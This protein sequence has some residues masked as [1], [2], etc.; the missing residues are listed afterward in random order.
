MCNTHGRNVYRQADCLSVNNS[1]I[2]SGGCCD[3][4][5]S[6]LAEDCHVIRVWHWGKEDLE[7][8]LKLFHGVRFCPR[9]DFGCVTVRTQYKE[10]SLRAYRFNYCM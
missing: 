5:D 2:M 6:A 3:I 10:M 1:V 4:Q 8:R 7:A 9:G